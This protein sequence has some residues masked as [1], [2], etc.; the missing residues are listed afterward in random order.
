MEE[1]LCIYSSR[2]IRFLK[3]NWDQISKYHVQ[4]FTY[5]PETFTKSV[6]ITFDLRNHERAKLF[7][8][9]PIQRK[10][11]TIFLPV[12]G[13]VTHDTL[14][15]ACTISSMEFIHT[16]IIL[17]L[18][19]YELSGRWAFPCFSPLVAAAWIVFDIYYNRVNVKALRP[20]FSFCTEMKLIRSLWIPRVGIW[21]DLKGTFLI[22]I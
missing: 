7:N 18:F 10:H 2:R 9:W 1:I 3:I 19:Q 6:L 12:F 15:F 14:L 22:Y 16:K 17:S 11:R 5:M 8:I 13:V 21:L 20:F 4:L